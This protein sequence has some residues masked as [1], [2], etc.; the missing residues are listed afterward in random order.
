MNSIWQLNLPENYKICVSG[1]L[2]WE[3][4][5]DVKNIVFLFLQKWKSEI[6]GFV[7]LQRFQP[8]ASSLV[9]LLFKNVLIWHSWCVVC[10]GSSWQAR[11]SPSLHLWNWPGEPGK[12]PLRK[13][14]GSSWSV[15]KKASMVQVRE[16]V[17]TYCPSETYLNSKRNNRRDSR[18]L[19]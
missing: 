1:N 6:N 4:Q 2:D 8:G 16:T 10:V 13:E 18:T 12:K 14:L 9:V 11:S 5:F 17:L 15:F 19:A 3:K 7:I